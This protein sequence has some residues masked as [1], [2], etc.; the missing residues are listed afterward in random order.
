[1]N[2]ARRRLTGPKGPFQKARNDT[3]SNSIRN[4]AVP[5]GCCGR[6]WVLGGV[7]SS[8]RSVPES[9]LVDAKVSSR[10]RKNPRGSLLEYSESFSVVSR[11]ARSVPTTTKR[12]SGT[13]KRGQQ[14]PLQKRTL[15]QRLDRLQ[16][17]VTRHPRWNF[18]S[19]LLAPRLC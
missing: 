10:K 7:Q 13:R 3:W 9:D 11:L 5:T 14:P 8:F 4:F 2:K 6:W 16:R 1:M 17:L 15:N 18:L 12:G 19:L